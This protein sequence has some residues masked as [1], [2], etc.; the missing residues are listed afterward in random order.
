MVVD[1]R[2]TAL[3]L[4]MQGTDVILVVA[5]GAPAAVSAGPGRLALMVGDPGDPA[6]AAA[7][8][9]MNAELFGARPAPAG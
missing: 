8:A 4:T 6:V 3:A 9:E 5:A 7:A 1:D 2:E